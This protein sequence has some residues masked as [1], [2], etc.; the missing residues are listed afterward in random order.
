[1]RER[2][3]VQTT[4]FGTTFIEVCCCNTDDNCNHTPYA[5]DVQPEAVTD[6]NSLFLRDEDGTGCGD[7]H[8]CSFIGPSN[9]HVITSND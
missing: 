5:D 3:F 6:I 1:V 8:I 7:I 4:S 2:H 9:D